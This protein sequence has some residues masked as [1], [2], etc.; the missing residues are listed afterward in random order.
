MAVLDDYRGATL[1]AW[2]KDHNL[3]SVKQVGQNSTSL[4]G[5][6]ALRTELTYKRDGES[7]RYEIVFALWNNTQ[8]ALEYEASK[9]S[10]KR[11]EKAFASVVDSFEFHCSAGGE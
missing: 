5:V 11:Y 10:A 9:H 1:D 6:P 8:Y 3:K 4:K 7:R 2:K